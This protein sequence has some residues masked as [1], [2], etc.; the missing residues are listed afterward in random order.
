LLLCICI[1]RIAFALFLLQSLTKV[2]VT[3]LLCHPTDTISDLGKRDVSNRR[4]CEC[5]TAPMIQKPYSVFMLQLLEQQLENYKLKSAVV[6]AFAM[7]FSPARGLHCTAFILRVDFGCATPPVTMCNI[8]GHRET[9][10]L[11]LNMG[12]ARHVC[13][14][15]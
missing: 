14:A 5:T 9:C 10:C 6:A 3:Y 12:E 4:H 13:A 1:L 15:P 8:H 7:S 2:C 11:P